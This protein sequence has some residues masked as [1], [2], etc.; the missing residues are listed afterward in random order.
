MWVY[1]HISLGI[2]NED[3]KKHKHCRGAN[4]MVK[5][6]M[7]IPEDIDKQIAIDKIKQDKKDK[8]DV[9]VDILRKHYEKSEE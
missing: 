1:S 8:R 3:N 4:I 2:K 6:Q 5:V 7:E 9:I